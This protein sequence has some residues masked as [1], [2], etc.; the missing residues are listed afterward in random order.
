MISSGLESEQWL[1]D[2]LTTRHP[3]TGW[4]ISHISLRTNAKTT[5]SRLSD[6]GPP[7]AL[8]TRNNNYIIIIIIIIIIIR[9]K[10]RHFNFIK[11]QEDANIQGRWSCCYW[12]SSIFLL[13]TAIVKLKR[14]YICGTYIIYAYNLPGYL[15]A[16]SDKRYLRFIPIFVVTFLYFPFPSALFAL[17]YLSVIYAWSFTW[18]LLKQLSG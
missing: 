18:M 5:N 12:M 10:R 4:K 13:I 14:L 6:S 9:Y 3:K 11:K 17:K 8:A 15:F 2:E 1:G 16:N 7:Y